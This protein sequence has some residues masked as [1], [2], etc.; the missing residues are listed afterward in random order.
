MDS[1]KDN[2]N[3][4]PFDDFEIENLKDHLNTSF[5]YDNIIVSEELIQKT[6]KAIEAG[7]APKI[8]E[9]KNQPGKHPV[10]R[11]A[12]VAAAVI[13]IL[14]GITVA[15]NGFI[16][17]DIVSEQSAETADQ[18][19]I[20]EKFSLKSVPSEENEN[21]KQY[22]LDSTSPS[23][24][25]DESSYDIAVGAGITGN[26]DNS[27]NGAGVDNGTAS[28]E[29]ARIDI[30]S[31][32]TSSMFAAENEIIQES[33]LFTDLLPVYDTIT[34]ITINRNN[35]N[36][37]IED[38][39]SDKKDFY[40]LLGGF[41]LTNGENISGSINYVIKIETSVKQLYTITI[42]DSV[43]IISEE[44]QNNQTKYYHLTNGSDVLMSRL[45]EFIAALD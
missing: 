33:I 29:D 18:S 14:A 26:T 28:M 42:N 12:Q 9:D 44:P 7:E 16:K 37:E 36:Y 20:E 32:E 3:K 23:V 17:K 27:A 39:L 35:I 34:K 22:S 4:K 10:F 11:I 2:R 21:T 25:E 40:D 30:T 13:V 8:K 19:E 24:G 5:D 43:Q 1:Y 45:D 31:E 6:K 41:S 38:S 15:Q